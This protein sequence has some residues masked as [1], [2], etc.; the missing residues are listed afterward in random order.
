[1]KIMDKDERRL[2][3]KAWDRRYYRT[4][5]RCVQCGE[6]FMKIP[7]VTFATEVYQPKGSRS[8]VKSE[9]KPKRLLRPILEKEDL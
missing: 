1:M 2:V 3:S 6:V 5:Y 8:E 9:V 4:V 7:G